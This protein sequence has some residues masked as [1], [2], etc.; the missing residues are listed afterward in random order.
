MQQIITEDI[1]KLQPKLL[2]TL[3]RRLREG[4]FEENGY[5]RVKKVKGRLILEPVRILS[6]PVRRYTEEEVNN[7]FAL[8][9]EDSKKL[10]KKG[11]I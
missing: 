3:P 5:V 9:E 7:F 8:D 2:L 11:L 6:Y 10:R 1:F 4:I